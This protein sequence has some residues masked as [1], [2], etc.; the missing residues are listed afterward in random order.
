MFTELASIGRE[1]ITIQLLESQQF[2]KLKTTFPVAGSNVV[3]DV[4][5]DPAQGRVSINEAQYFGSVPSDA[6][7]FF[8]GGYRVAEKWLRDRRDRKLIYEEIQHY[9]R[10]IS[11]LQESRR[12]MATVDATVAQYGGWP[13][14]GVA[15][16]GTVAEPAVEEE[17]PKKARRGRRRGRR[18]P[19]RT[20][21]LSDLRATAGWTCDC[22][23]QPCCRRMSA[24]TSWT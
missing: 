16:A 13:I 3:E 20:T 22:T 21:G 5:F 19:K 8:V 10:I 1:L 2:A 24:R 18:Q 17:A 14:E 15:P 4:E 11:A 23:R 6:W 7:D 9:Q 12:L